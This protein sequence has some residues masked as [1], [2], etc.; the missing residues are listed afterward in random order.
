MGKT[1]TV[2]LRGV[3]ATAVRLAKV[4]ASSEENDAT[5]QA[6]LGNVTAMEATKSMMAASLRLLA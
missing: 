5:A 4:E 1:A 2:F 6:V 3:D